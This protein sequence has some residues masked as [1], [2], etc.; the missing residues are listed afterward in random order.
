M[1]RTLRKIKNVGIYSAFFGISILS[2]Q[3]TY[4]F[5]NAS[6]IGNIGPTAPQI[7]AAYLS[8]N[9]NGSVTVSSGVQSF[10]VP[11][12]GPYRIS[13]AGAQG[14]HSVYNG[15]LGSLMV[16]DFTLTAGQVLKIV[17]GQ[18]GLNESGDIN[19]SGGGGGGSFVYTGTTLYVAAGG[20]AGKTGYSSGA[21]NFP[22]AN[23]NALTTGNAGSGWSAGTGGAG[24][25]AGTGGL[26]SSYGGGGAGWLSD[27]GDASSYAGNQ[28]GFSNL[29]NWLGGVAPVGGGD[30]GFGGAGA[31][32]IAYGGGGGGG[33]YSGGGG[34]TDP[35]SGGGAGS[36]NS[37]INQI[38]TAS[39]NIGNGK[40]I[41]TSLYG[42]GISQ[43]SSITCNG[44]LTGALSATVNGGTG[45]FT[46]SWSPTGGTAITATGLGA[47]TYTC[48]AT[49]A[50]S[51][52]VS[53]T[54]VITQP[55]ILVSTVGSQTN[56]SCNAGTN[57]A[58]TLTTTG[59]TAP[60]SYTWSP[61]GGSAATAS[62]LV[63]NTYS[64]IVKD[65]NLCTAT[66][67]PSATITQPASFSISASASNSVI[68]GSGSTALTA[69]GAA[70]YT[71]TGGVVNGASFS[72][73]VTNT[74]SATA[75]NSL[76]CAASNTAVVT[77]NVGTTPTVT[78]NSGVIC[79][80]KSFTMVPAGASTYNYSGGSAVVSPTANT[81]YTVTGASVAGCTNTA[82]SSITVNASPSVVASTSNSVICVGNSVVLTASTSATSYTWNTGAT[83]MSVSVSPTVTS[84]YTVSVSNAAACVASSTVMV[85][86]NPCT[87]INEILAN[88][89]SVY[90]N[91]ANGIINV[92][93][94]S[95]LAQN[96][97]LEVYDALGKLVLKQVLA[98]D[99]NS[100]NISNLDNGIY[101]FKVL[102][103]FNIVKVG[104]LIKQ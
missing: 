103:N 1:E 98:N 72:P 36:Y 39:V 54:F 30:G 90:P 75:T 12:T 86:V 32:G 55:A 15:G 87:G 4:T 73:T 50:V 27:G 13:A 52:T 33:G 37:G 97:S 94:T 85:T 61:T 19:R 81:S 22:T 91:P 26:G 60:Y 100:I 62:G 102:N 49:S 20:G 48:V 95:E 71:W 67:S 64:C 29:A 51:G 89:I 59:G 16:G 104:K 25:A 56:V 84:T 5:T 41:I 101:T 65:V 47:G 35:G 42:V 14:G 63:A 7:T 68:C 46:Y 45:P 76:G 74:Y 82:V 66:T 92:D 83:T 44:L 78:V 2:A 21:Y 70:T 77:V 43:T 93:L 8:T 40:I 31:G 80:G 53:S 6:A 96:S 23:A 99:L 9:L 24:G 34:G 88:S 79:A 18:K 3:T 11:T 17:V 38:N 28:Q 58:I 57:G 69:S 10:T